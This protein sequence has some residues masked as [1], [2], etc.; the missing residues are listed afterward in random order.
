MTAADAR[1]EKLTLRVRRVP[2]VPIVAA[3]I[4]LWGGLRLEEIPGQALVTG[5]M[6]AEGTQQRRWDE[7]AVEAE[8]LG[9]LVQTFGTAET[10]CVSI[11]ALAGDWRQTLEWLAEL[12]LEPAFPGDRFQWIRRQVA[13]ELESLLD[14]PEARAGC[15]FLE[16]LYHPHPFS[17]PPQG[18]A[19]GLGRLTAADCAAFHARALGWGGTVTVT[20]EID[21][22]A[23]ERR[24]T[25]LF[26]GWS[27]R[28]TATRPT[29]TPAISPCRAIIR[30]TRRCRSSGWCW[31]PAPV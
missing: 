23:V 5:R 7:I 18:D 15:A 29:S 25:E 27:R 8:D 6:L 9:V 10:L 13:A 2:G 26:A 24:L 12:T 28:A 3:R 19:D 16:Q 30:T 21:E 17:R 22:A 11:E 31:A 1:P 14:Q 4:W 20:G